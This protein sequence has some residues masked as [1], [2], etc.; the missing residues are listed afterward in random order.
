M[1][2]VRP[3]ERGDGDQRAKDA[4]DE[5]HVVARLLFFDVIVGEVLFH[6]V[7]FFRLL[8]RCLLGGLK[9]NRFGCCR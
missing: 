3:N 9:F 2:N 6:A 1:G 8:S 4:Q 7:S 5:H